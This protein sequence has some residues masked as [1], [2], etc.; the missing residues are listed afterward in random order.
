METSVRTV[1]I[2]AILL[3]G[4]AV[5]L[6]GLA[7]CETLNLAG[8]PAASEAPVA[9]ADEDAAYEIGPGDIL[10]IQV[11]KNPE[12]S[13]TVPV[14]PDGMISVPLLDDVQAAGLTTLELKQS[15]TD[16]FKEYIRSP[17]VTVIVN[18]INSKRVS[19]VGEVA[20]PSAVPLQVDM[21]VLDAIA[22]VG[23]F[24]TFADRSDIRILRPQG[25]GGVREF[26]FNAKEFMKGQNPQANILLQPG[27]TI[28]VTD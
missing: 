22:L 16:S 9:A 23:G 4:L 10:R 20:R 18:E 8:T 2:R 11:W 5:S 7:G 26:R 3:A 25:D 27:D 24:S 19:I 6:G 1:I 17:D 15:L 12:L 13:A 28:V 21:R 14:R